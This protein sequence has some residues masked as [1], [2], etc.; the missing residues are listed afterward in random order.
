MAI[1]EDVGTAAGQNRY[2]ADLGLCNYFWVTDPF[3][4]LTEALA[5]SSEKCVAHRAVHKLQRVQMRW[6]QPWQMPEQKGQRAGGMLV[7]DR[8]GV[9]SQSLEGPGPQV[10][11]LLGCNPTKHQ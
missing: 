10:S 9:C 1:R 8:L 4:K 6:G 3:E 2:G 5:S 11:H 7:G